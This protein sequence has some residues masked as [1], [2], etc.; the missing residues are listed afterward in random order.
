M[1]RQALGAKRLG[2]RTGKLTK[3]ANARDGILSL[4]T[5]RAGALAAKMPLRNATPETV[6]GRMRAV[7]TKLADWHRPQ[8]AHAAP[9][10]TLP[11]FA[12]CA[13]VRPGMAAKQRRSRGAGGK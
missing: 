1:E 7:A 6:P 3:A 8:S 11:S 10:L 13:Q 12:A 9:G 4:R 5:V 2:C